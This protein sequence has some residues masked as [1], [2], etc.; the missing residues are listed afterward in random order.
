MKKI[1]ITL[2][3][4]QLIPNFKGIIKCDPDFTYLVHTEMSEGDADWIKK[5]LDHPSDKVKV[6]TT[7][8]AKITK[9][10][11]ARLPSDG[12]L[13]VNITAAP[14]PMAFALYEKYRNSDNA[15]IFY[16]DQSDN[17][18]DIKTH[19]I[20]KLQ[21]PIPIKIW[22]SLQK[23]SLTSFEIFE[24]SNEK[25]DVVHQLRNIMLN[26]GKSLSF[27]LYKLREYQKKP[28]VAHNQIFKNG[29]D[30]IKYDHFN[31]EIILTFNYN[32][33]TLL[34]MKDI[35]TFVVLT[36]WFEYE[37]AQ[38]LSKWTKNTEMLLSLVFPYSNQ[39]PK[40]EIDIAVNIGNK[41][42]AIETKTSLSDIK[43]IDKFQNA[44]KTYFGTSATPVLITDQPL[45]TTQQEKCSDLSVVYICLNEIRKRHNDLGQSLIDIIEQNI[46]ENNRQ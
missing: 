28:E 30:S 16:L 10:L 24:A 2:V 14:K 33:S 45:K 4:G 26:N 41:I 31:N 19:Q 20:E 8:I 18:V 32:S 6:D 25:N 9:E 42:V 44:V 12:Q 36:R 13:F 1:H 39:S 22:I 11:N 37:V 29:K 46:K 7:D 5:N 3:G 35:Y 23:S 17:Y 34:K 40:N 15:T 21:I 27:L 38:M 43:D